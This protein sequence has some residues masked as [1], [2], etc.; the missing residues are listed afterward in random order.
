[1]ADG[2]FDTKEIQQLILADLKKLPVIKY[3]PKNSRYKRLEELPHLDWRFLNP[4]LADTSA[5]HNKYK[6]RTAV[7]R[8]TGRVKDGT[9]IRRSNMRALHN[10]HKFAYFGVITM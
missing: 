4:L 1:M 8:L 10:N 9:S 3:N 5:Y 6:E 2:I 7:E